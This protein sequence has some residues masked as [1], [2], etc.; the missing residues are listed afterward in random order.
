MSAPP[1]LDTNVVLYAFTP[2]G[3]KTTAAERILL[4]GGVVSVQVLNELTSV[5]RTKF[6]MD[7]TEVKQL[8][9]GTTTMC[10][11]PKALVYETYLEGRRISE[12]FG[13]S[14]WDGLILASAL[15]AG[16][17]ILYTEDL[18][19]GQVV[20]GVRIENPFRQI[21]TP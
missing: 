2:S 8:I 5:A 9:Q 7:W 12:R 18:Q 20:E 17:P 16:C 4:Q 21:A 1:F 3:D 19:H 15:D 13:F 14:I 6:R 10:P 11:N